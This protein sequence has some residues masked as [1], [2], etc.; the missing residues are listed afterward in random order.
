MY[1]TLCSVSHFIIFVS[2]DFLYIFDDSQNPWFLARI[3]HRH[4]I[5]D[6]R[7][8]IFRE[9]ENHIRNYNCTCLLGAQVGSIHEIYKGGQ[10]RDTVPLLATIH[11]VGWRTMWRGPAPAWTMVVPILSS[12]PA[13]ILPTNYYILWPPDDVLF[14]ILRFVKHRV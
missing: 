11:L 1:C 6:L 7:I 2:E 4:G 8:W 13:T 14:S 10:S 9:I 12:L 5:L 3:H